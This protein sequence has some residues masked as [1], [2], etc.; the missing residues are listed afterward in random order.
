MNLR[1]YSRLI[2]LAHPGINVGNEACEDV[3]VMHVSCERRHALAL[4]RAGVLVAL[5]YQAQGIA[6]GAHTREGRA[7][8]R[9]E[10]SV[11]V[12]SRE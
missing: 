8:P 4:C 9:G 2:R 6:L 3:D 1:F 12:L 5:L 10:E 11:R 7:E